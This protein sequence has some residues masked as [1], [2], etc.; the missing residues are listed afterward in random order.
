MTSLDEINTMVHKVM[1]IVWKVMT[2]LRTVTTAKKKVV[3]LVVNEVPSINQGF[4]PLKTNDKL[5]TR[6]L[7]PTI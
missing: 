1:T 6:L 3:I 4:D 7:Y 5:L 2:S